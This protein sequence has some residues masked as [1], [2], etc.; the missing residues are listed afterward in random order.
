MKTFMD[1]ELLSLDDIQH[2]QHGPMQ[3][4]CNIHLPKEYFTDKHNLV[5]T[6]SEDTESGLGSFY[7]SAFKIGD[8]TYGIGMREHLLERGVELVLYGKK[9]DKPPAFDQF[10]S[11]F[12]LDLK[13]LDLYT[14]Y[15]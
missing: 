6:Y 12:N 11:I 9:E 8:Y 4:I 10:Q 15:K 13:D 14:D 3:S 1:V 7:M 5:F 2:G